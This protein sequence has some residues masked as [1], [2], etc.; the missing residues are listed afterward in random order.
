MILTG[1]TEVL[2]EKHYTAWVVDGWMSM[3]QCW[4]DTEI[5]K[6]KCLKQ[7]VLLA[8]SRKRTHLSAVR[9]LKLTDAYPFSL[10]IDQRP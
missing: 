3:D 2:G 8:I 1:E 9:S 6:L 5:R 4:N 7:N 10:C